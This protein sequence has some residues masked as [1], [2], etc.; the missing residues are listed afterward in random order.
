MVSEVSEDFRLN[1]EEFRLISEVF[2]ID[3]R[4]YFEDYL[5][6][7]FYIIIM[8]LSNFSASKVGNYIIIVLVSILMTV[9]NGCGS[10]E[11]KPVN[12][13]AFA[14]FS[15][16]LTLSEYGREQNNLVLT[17]IEY[18]TQDGRKLIDTFG[19]NNGT[20]RTIKSEDFTRAGYK[21]SIIITESLLNGVQY[22]QD[23]YELGLKVDLVVT[24]YGNN[25]RIINSLSQSYTDGASVRTENLNRRYPRM[26]TLSFSVDRDGQVT[27]SKK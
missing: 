2:S 13:N 21:G 24:S 15:F 10:D 4:S 8:N 19:K 1:F 12:E 18:T 11:P 5:I 22:E 14:K 27:I 26:V 6:I 20:I 7:S 16:D 23:S 17:T 9:L 3:F 25:G